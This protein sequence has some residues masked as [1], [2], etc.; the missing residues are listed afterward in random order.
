MVGKKTLDVATST[1]KL[2]LCT[3]TTTSVF[4][5][6]SGVNNVCLSNFQQDFSTLLQLFKSYQKAELKLSKFVTAVV[7]QDFVLALFLLLFGSGTI[8]LGGRWGEY[9]RPWLGGAKWE[10]WPQDEGDQTPWTPCHR[11]YICYYLNHP[12]GFKRKV[13]KFW[14]QMCCVLDYQL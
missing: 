14:K 7:C 9:A 11:I 5:S 10:I 4:Y 2:P 8:W 3:A 12:Y 13:L 1:A 6:M